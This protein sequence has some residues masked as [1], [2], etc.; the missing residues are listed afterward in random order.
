MIRFMRDADGV[1]MG[2]RLRIKSL[3]KET[4]MTAISQ[5]G[6]G[7][8]QTRRTLRVLIIEDSETDAFLLERA[9]QRG[10]L[11]SKCH[12]V[13]TSETMMTALEEQSWDVI[14]ADHS[15]PLFSAPEALRLLQ[16]RG[17]DVPFIIVSGHIEEVTAV[18]AMKSGAH[19][20]IMKD[21]LARLVPAVERELREAEMRHAQRECE[22]ALRRAHDE[23]EIRVER[24]TVALKEANAKL[25][26]AFE[27]RRRLENELLEIAENERR[28][29][30][31]DLHDDLGQKLTG[32][33]L[34]TQAL[35]QRLKREK[36]GG[37]P[38]ASRISEL[39]NEVIDHTHNLAHQFSAMDARGNDLPD[40]LKG[41]AADVEKMF[42]IPCALEI[43]GEIPAL[44]NHS[45]QQFYKIAQEAISN[46]VKHGQAARVWISVNRGEHKLALTIKNDGLPFSL[47]EEKK[48]RMG[49][50]IMNY[51][52]NTIG[53]TFEIKPNHKNGT[54]CTCTLPVGNNSNSSLKEEAL[55]PVK[56]AAM[57]RLPA[58]ELVTAR[59]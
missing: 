47:P 58:R 24:R 50:R 11:N 15:M 46:A 55:N 19:D 36:H 30:G 21:N 17:L 28:S 42:G 25:H 57:G 2:W 22:A 34:L 29:I 51:R 31:F 23:L 37:A 39:V 48:S 53:A 26:A 14:L 18:S 35:E 16:Q 56:V 45:I 3:S 54:I 12:R 4:F 27:E 8:F 59:L 41:L 38:D 1:S 33:L 6:D 20:Y 9:L 5:V 7:S 13:D 49:L 40:V 43:K 32:I 52:A 44:P 10:G